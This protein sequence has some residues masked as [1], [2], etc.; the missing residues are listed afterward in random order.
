MPQKRQEKELLKLSQEKRKQAIPGEDA[1]LPKKH[2]TA[3][4][5]PTD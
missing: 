1:S 3:G 4:W 5:L 2:D